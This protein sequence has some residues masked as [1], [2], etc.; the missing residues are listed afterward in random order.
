MPLPS[1]VASF[2]GTRKRSSS[3]SRRTRVAISVPGETYWPVSMARVWITPAIGERTMASRS[4]SSARER[5]VFACWISARRRGDPRPP[6][7]DLFGAHQIR[8]LHVHRLAALESVLRLV[9]GRLRLGERRPGGRGRQGVALGLDLGERRR[10]GHAVAFAEAHALDHA[11]DPRRHGHLF[12]RFDRSDRAH[13][14]LDV[15][16]RDPGRLDR[17]AYFGARR[18]SGVGR[19]PAAAGEG[20]SPGQNAGGERRQTAPAE[21]GRCH[22]TSGDPG[23]GASRG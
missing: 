16:R 5:A 23:D 18:A 10:G 17:K 21:S 9:R 20:E 8:V 14:V 2:C 13:A 19:L 15:A 3:G 6:G 22:G 11:G 12:E 7:V 1:G 4:L